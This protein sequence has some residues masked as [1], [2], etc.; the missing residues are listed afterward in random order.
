[1]IS[2]DTDA[3]ASGGNRRSPGFQFVASAFVLLLGLFGSHLATPLYPIWQAE[4]GLA[5]GAITLIYA[6]YPIGVTG[7]LLFGG[8]LGDQVG[9]KPLILSG[10]LLMIGSAAIY[11]AAT[12]MPALVAARL[13]NGVAIG[14]LSGPAVALIVELHPQQNRSEGS[15]IGAL[16]TLASPAVGLLAAT[17]IVYFAHSTAVAVTLPFILQIAGIIVGIMLMMTVRETILPENKV[18][19]R[20]ASF[21][22]QGLHIPAGIRSGFLFAALIGVLAWANTGLWLSLG[23]SLVYEVLGSHNRLLGGLMVV[24]FLTTAG[25]VQLFTRGM[26]FPRAI[27]LGLALVIPSIVIVNVMLVW[28]SAIGLAVGVALAGASQGLSWMGCSQLINH[29]AP[30]RYRASV[31]S[32]LYI[33]GYFGSS[34]PVIATGAA[35]DAIG[36]FP[37]LLLLSAL[38]VGLAIYLI[39]TNVRINRAGFAPPAA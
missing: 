39:I 4:F 15:R 20:D 32:A 17:M 12:G 8:R 18:R 14:L 11:L 2:I 6:C 19:W 36:L 24:A 37:A 38:F 28:H 25:V 35:A 13:L 3:A 22:P 16:A 23:P 27:T 5:T 21:A 33:C 34:I 7:G 29:I 9:R 26:E 31:V 30:S 1:M 10:L